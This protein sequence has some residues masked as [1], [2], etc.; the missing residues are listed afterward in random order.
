LGCNP[1]AT[2]MQIEAPKKP[3]GDDMFIVKLNTVALRS[4]YE[5]TISVRNV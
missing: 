5:T 4:G 1:D 2:A 3:V